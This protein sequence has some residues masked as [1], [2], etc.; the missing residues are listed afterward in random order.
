MKLEQL[1]H[2]IEVSNT[3]SFSQAAKKL[4]MA[5]PNLSRSVKRLEEELGYSIFLRTSTGVTPTPK[6]LALIEH[7]RL[8]YMECQIMADTK[9]VEKSVQRERLNFAALRS[10]NTAFLPMIY[11]KYANSSISSVCLDC[12]S[13]EEIIQLIISA[14]IDFAVI[15][16]I[17]PFISATR[18]KLHNLDIEYHPYS[19]S[20]IYAAVGPHNPLY[21]AERTTLKELQSHTIVSHACINGDNSM[22]YSVI[23]GIENEAHGSIKTN[24]LKV[25]NQLIYETMVV[26]L[27]ATPPEL[28]RTICEYKDIRL[29]NIVDSDLSVEYAWIK[30]RR[31]PLSELAKESL[32]YHLET[33]GKRE[34]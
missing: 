2:I 10:R 14:Q 20:R 32:A 27:V 28:F 22:N 9:K 29:L 11:Q 13:M 12:S 34:Q 30:L 8:A 4:Y 24:S 21:E 16:T 1:R 26:G 6:G 25:F 7:A 15:E 18:T 33:F 23:L 17:S 19:N 5:Q 31:F 3:G